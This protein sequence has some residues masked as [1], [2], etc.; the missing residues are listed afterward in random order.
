MAIVAQAGVF[1]FGPQSGK[2]VAASALYKHRAADIDLAVIS[3]DR[4]GPPEVGGTPT[5]TLPYRAGVM[6]AGGAT[7]SPRLENTFG[8]LLYGVA[9]DVTSTIDEDVLG[10]TATGYNHH[11]FTFDPSSEGF[12]P[13]MTFY[14][15]IPGET[16]GDILAEKYQ[17]SK[18]VN[19][20]LALPNDGLIQARIDAIGRMGDNAFS[21]TPE[22]FENT[23]YEDFT[24]VPI[25]SVEGSY[26]QIPGY[27]ATDLPIV[28]CTVS[29]AN[30]PMDMRQEKIF[31]SPY[32][33]DI[34]VIG[35]SLTVDMIV[36]WRDPELYRSILTGS[37]TGTSWSACPFVSDLD[38]LAVT[39]I[40][41]GE[42]YP[43]QIR[44]QAPE[45][46]YQLVGGIRL[47][48][49]EAVMQ[50]IQGTAIKGSSD[51]YQLHLCNTVT[52]Y[53]WPA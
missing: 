33:E 24:S 20:N 23:E 46:M 8:W 21:S 43:Y 50:R 25:G 4:L 7:I 48:G 11:V 45:I 28:A 10:N 51:Y 53:A 22:T 3:D 39:G 38:V 6:A 13:W 26:I 44:V 9:G 29:L 15:E 42:T 2:E 35:R 49:N 52:E 19:L 40:C 1:G 12:V 31:G 30:T 16:A 32:L 36:K 5:P 14:K 17:D 18:I 37:T 27:S 47:A 34:T 41:A